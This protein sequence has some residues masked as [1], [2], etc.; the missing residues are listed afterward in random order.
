LLRGNKVTYMMGLVSWQLIPLL[1]DGERVA[2][3]SSAVT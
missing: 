3:S 1:P 2:I